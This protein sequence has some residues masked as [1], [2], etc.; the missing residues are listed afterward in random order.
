MNDPS[1][2]KEAATSALEFQLHHSIV[3]LWSFAQLENAYIWF[4][5][6]VVCLVRGEA[7]QGNEATF[8]SLVTLSPVFRF[9]RTNDAP[10]TKLAA[11]HL[12][13]T[14]SG[15][16]CV[17]APFI[18]QLRGVL[19][20]AKHATASFPSLH[21]YEFIIK[22]CIPIL[23]NALRR[24]MYVEEVGAPLL[25]LLGNVTFQS[26]RGR[27]LHIIRSYCLQSA[28][29]STMLR[30]NVHRLL[31]RILLSR[32]T[33]RENLTRAAGTLISMAVIASHNDFISIVSEP[34][35]F[36]AYLI[37]L[38]YNDSDAS[39]IQSSSAR[40][41]AYGEALGD[42]QNAA[43]RNPISGDACEPPA[44]NP[45]LELL[46]QRHRNL[47]V[48]DALQALRPGLQ[49]VADAF[50]KLSETIH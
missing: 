16:E 50:S 35:F 19:E 15:L 11:G 30:C 47:F 38:L 6:L 48:N 14:L 18:M 32:E 29:I 31:P 46:Y 17:P 1:L 37:C 5:E 13:K 4:L 10:S 45:W 25:R 3:A 7:L 34:K 27:L 12:F 41:L 28:S 39:Y 24:D 8:A 44:A 33:E 26:V 22:T 2:M 43:A 23:L 40:V 36:K 21:F 20:E 9:L 49:L 42:V